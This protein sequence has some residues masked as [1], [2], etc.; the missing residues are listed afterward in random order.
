MVVVHDVLCRVMKVFVRVVVEAEV[1][2][3]RGVFAMSYDG[4][5]MIY[6]VL[7]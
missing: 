5:A 6:D 3:V 7:L 4:F 2:K 1:L